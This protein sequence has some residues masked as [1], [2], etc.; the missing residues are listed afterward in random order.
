VFSGVFRTNDFYIEYRVLTNDVPTDQQSQDIVDFTNDYVNEFFRTT[1][2]DYTVELFTSV[3]FEE[4]NTASD[5][6]PP[7]RDQPARIRLV[8]DTSL[9]LADNSPSVPTI[10]QV[11]TDLARA[12]ENGT[13]FLTYLTQMIAAFPDT[14]YGTTFGADWQVI[15]QVG[16]RIRAPQYEY[17]KTQNLNI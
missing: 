17:V 1:I 10:D 3:L 16:A 8:F 12:F 4:I 9:T 11:N 6:D 14:P 13:T 7:T 2:T 15:T 5:V